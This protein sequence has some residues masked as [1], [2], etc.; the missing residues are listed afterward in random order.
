MSFY[1]NFEC[2]L[3]CLNNTF[4]TKNGKRLCISG[5]H[6]H[7]NDVLGPEN[8]NFWKWISKFKFQQY[9]YHIQVNYKMWI[10]ENSDITHAY[11]V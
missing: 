7:N 4:S 11:Y 10:C 2:D 9:H 6:L 1:N 3:L 8:A 5:I